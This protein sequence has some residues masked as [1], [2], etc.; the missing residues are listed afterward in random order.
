MVFI[1][2][3]I[4]HFVIFCYYLLKVYSFLVKDRKGVDPNGKGCEEEWEGVQERVGKL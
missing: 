1:L 4:F 2:S 3:Y